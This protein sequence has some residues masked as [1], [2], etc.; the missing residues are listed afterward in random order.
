MAANDIG[1]L[2][3]QTYFE[4]NGK[5]YAAGFEIYNPQLGKD[6]IPMVLNNNCIQKFEFVSE[7]EPIL[8][9]ILFF[10]INNHP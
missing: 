1:D 9:T 3:P 2:K 7:L 8:T 5:Y 4:Y 10:S 6:D